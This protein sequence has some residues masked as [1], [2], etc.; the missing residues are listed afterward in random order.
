M[1]FTYKEAVRY[2]QK[3]I[4]NFNPHALEQVVDPDGKPICLHYSF[5]MQVG[6]PGC[7]FDV[8][9]VFV[10]KD[11]MED[12]EFYFDEHQKP[13]IVISDRDCD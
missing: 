11:L 2:L 3:N 13:M 5:C 10:T 12:V 9:V 6:M 4:G 1:Q 7:F 8:D